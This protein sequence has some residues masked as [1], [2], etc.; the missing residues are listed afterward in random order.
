MKATIVLTTTFA[1]LTTLHVHA[2]ATSEADSL[3]KEFSVFID[4]PWGL[5]SESGQPISSPYVDSAGNHKDSRKSCPATGLSSPADM[6]KP[7]IWFEAGPD[8]TLIERYG[9]P[10]R[11][12][13]GYYNSGEQFITHHFAGMKSKDT[14]IFDTSMH[15][16]LGKTEITI[17]SQNKIVVQHNF[18]EKTVSSYIRCPRTYRKD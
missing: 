18:I 17:V 12:E 5:A 4:G 7:E 14:A 1:L 2:A 8:K 10:H 11:N 13:D 6:D 16:S 15:S 3:F 9:S